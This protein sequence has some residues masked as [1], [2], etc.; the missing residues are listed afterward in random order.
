MTSILFRYIFKE[1]A[2]PFV[3]GMAVFTFVLL[4]GRLLKLAE[5]VFAKGVPFLD[6]CRLILYMLPSFL[7]VAIPM[8]FLLA[9]LLSFGRLS[10]DSEVT[11]MKAGGVGLGSLLTP[12][13]TFAVLAY[14]VTTFITVYAL[15]WGNTSFKRFLYEVIESRAATTI[16]E[17]VFIDDF[18]GLVVY[19]D[20]YDQASHQIS[21]ILVHDERN[22]DE[23]MTIFAS[24]GIIAAAP[25]EKNVR[26]HLVN[27]SIHRGIDPGGYRLV[28]FR[29]Y[30]LHVDLRQNAKKNQFDEQDMTL[31]QLIASR[32]NRQNNEKFRRDISIELHK[33]FALPFACIV[34][35][36]VGVPLGIQNQRSGRAGGFSAG[37]IILMLYYVVMSAGKTIAE[38]EILPIPLAVWLP[39][40]F[41]TAFGVYLLRL[42]ATERPFPL[43]ERGRTLIGE[44]REWLHR[45]K[46]A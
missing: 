43:I 21:G 37:I 1:T 34:F 45:R 5:M 7:L 18:P 3:L 44:A 14:L 38:K 12:V 30:D 22:P 31:K 25:E 36:M 6:V 33:R 9:V 19:I 27:G 32:G 20:D 28:E 24:T 16:K 41:F 35:A 17:K 26:L 10:A 39:N 42:A 29:S 13:F 15:P 11:A 46:A 8:A 2:V 40:V 4:M 23:P